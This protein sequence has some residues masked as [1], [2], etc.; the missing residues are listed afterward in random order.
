MNTNRGALVA[1]LVA[2]LCNLHVLAQAPVPQTQPAA[3]SVCPDEAALGFKPLFNGRDLDDWEHNGKPGSFSVVDG[4]IVGDRAEHKDAAYWLSTRR[5]YGDFELRLQVRIRPKGN[6]GIFIR[7]PR[8]GRTS[9]VG[10][11]IQ[12]IDDGAKSGEPGVSNTGA[13]Y[14]VVAPRAFV[15]RPAGEWNDLWILCEGDR[16]RVTLN[17]QLINDARMSDY[18]ALAARPREGYIGL[19][20][21]TEPV[22]FRNLRLREIHMPSTQPASTRPAGR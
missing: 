11:E 20:A 10:M 21:H 16:V 13:I 15:A 17:G 14:Q 6:T 4:C 5:Q 3:A 22:H 2:S 7:A 1:P 19:S 8:E 12:F 18:P 9:R